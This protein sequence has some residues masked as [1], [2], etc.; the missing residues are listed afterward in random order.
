MITVESVLDVALMDVIQETIALALDAE[1]PPPAKAPPR[2]PLGQWLVENMPR[3]ANLEIPG[4]RNESGRDFEGME[5]EIIDPWLL[6]SR[7]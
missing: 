3:G 7:A 5:V 1:R 2:Q 4:D 6:E